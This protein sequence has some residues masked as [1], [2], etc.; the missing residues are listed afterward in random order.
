[1]GHDAAAKKGKGGKLHGHFVA[2]P[3][4][5]LKSNAYRK[6][7]LAARCLLWDI[8]IQ[9]TGHNN[10]DL[11]PSVKYLAELG[12]NSRDTVQRAKKE[13][14]DV[15]LLFLTAQGHKPRKASQY[16]LTWLPL[17]RCDGFDPGTEK[18]FRPNEY[19]L[20]GPPP[21]VRKTVIKP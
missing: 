21:D 3:R 9:F 16:A 4:Q 12:W 7:S 20:V 8:A 10:G 6:L 1:V 11:R 15:G 17:D 19:L 14:V 18:A 5:V 13:L 2:I